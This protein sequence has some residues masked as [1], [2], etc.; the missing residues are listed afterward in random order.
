MHRPC[1][2]GQCLSAGPC[3]ATGEKSCG[4][5]PATGVGE[6]SPRADGQRPGGTA[7]RRL[8]AGPT[9]GP[10]LLR[11]PGPPRPRGR[12]DATRTCLRARSPSR[13]H[14]AT[15][16]GR[17]DLR[18]APEAGRSP[19]RACRTGPTRRAQVPTGGS[20]RPLRLGL[21]R[22]AR[23]A[24]SAPGRGARPPPRRRGPPM[25]L[26]PTLSDESRRLAALRRRDVLDTVPEAP[27][28]ASPASSRASSAAPTPPS[29]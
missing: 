16:D 21:G 12:P 1:A 19:C 13:C 24:R 10:G 20:S 6:G 5:G 11:I 3:P 18:V 2:E 27:S 25:Q 29:A 23:P 28:S 9:V 7:P 14:G 4:S 17:H 15:H 8:S 26:G 22:V